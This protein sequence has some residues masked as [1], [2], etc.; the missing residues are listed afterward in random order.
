M[1]ALTATGCFH[2]DAHEGVEAVGEDEEQVG[3]AGTDAHL[4]ELGG[5]HGVS[6]AAVGDVEEV[7]LQAR[8]FQVEPA[9]A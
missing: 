8:V 9:H 2:L 7:F 5:F 3:H 6:F 1:F 4:L